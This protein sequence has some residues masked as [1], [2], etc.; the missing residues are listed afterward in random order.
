MVL[1]GG[2]MIHGLPKRPV[3]ILAPTTG[4][5]PSPTSASSSATRLQL[6]L[7]AT[8]TLPQS[9][10]PQTPQPPPNVTPPLDATATVLLSQIMLPERPLICYRQFGPVDGVRDHHLAVEL[11]RRSLVKEWEDKGIL[12]TW[13]TV[14]RM[15]RQSI[16]LWVF[17]VSSDD[18]AAHPSSS[19]DAL[20]FDDMHAIRSGRFTPRDLYPCS[21]TCNHPTK[22]CDNCD[23]E[24]PPIQNNVPSSCLLPRSSLRVPFATFLDAL[25]GRLID[26]I[27]QQQRHRENRR[28]TDPPILR[29]NDG[30]LLGQQAHRGSWEQ[31]WG[32]DAQA[33]TSK[34]V[35]CQ[36]H[37]S[38]LP[39]RLLVQ[40]I[41]TKAPLVPL[42]PTPPAGTPVVL[43]PY[44]TPAYYLGPYIG[45]K[46]E[47]RAS[48]QESLKGLGCRSWEEQGLI[49]CWLTVRTGSTPNAS[50]AA[51]GPKPPTIQERGSMV[52]W[53]IS[54]CFY[55]TSTS[56]QPLV[57]LPS[58]PSSVCQPI[59]PPRTL[60]TGANVNPTA[61]QAATEVVHSVSEEAASPRTSSVAD[62]LRHSRTSSLGGIKA[63]SADATMV[64]FGPG[65]DTVAT[66]MG[67]YVEWTVKEREREKE[68]LVKEKERERERAKKDVERP[69]G[70][71]VLP[72]VRS[73]EPRLMAQQ[74]S[75]GS[76]G[77][78]TDNV[79]PAGIQRRAHGSI[80]HPE[81]YYPSP[82]DFNSSTSAPIGVPSMLGD[83]I[84]ST[85]EQ[86][87]VTQQPAPV[88]DWNMDIAT[89][90]FDLT[91]ASM[92]AGT[93]GFDTDTV[94][95]MTRA[96]MGIEDEFT[97]DDFNFFDGPQVP[98]QPQL[99]GA[100]LVDM[101]PPSL[102]KQPQVD[103]TNPFDSTSFESAGGP[104]V[105]WMDEFLSGSQV[106]QES[107]SLNTSYPDST[108]NAHASSDPSYLTSEI[109]QQPQDS[110]IPSPAHIQQSHD[111][112][113][114]GSALP[115]SPLRTPEPSTIASSPYT[116]ASAE[117]E[118]EEEDLPPAPADT[119]HDLPPEFPFRLKEYVAVGYKAIPFGAALTTA[120]QKYTGPGGKFNPVGAD[121]PPYQSPSSDPPELPIDDS[122]Y[123]AN[124]FLETVAPIQQSSSTAL[125]SKRATEHLLLSRTPHQPEDEVEVY[126]KTL[127]ARL[128]KLSNKPARQ[129]SFEIWHSK[130]FFDK[131]ST[132]TD[133]RV[134]LVKRLRGQK[135]RLEYTPYAYLRS[136]GD[137]D[138]RDLGSKLVEFEDLV[139]A[140]SPMDDADEEE[141]SDNESLRYATDGETLF[142]GE[143]DATGSGDGSAGIRIIR[144]DD[145][146]SP[147][148]PEHMRE[149]R[150]PPPAPPIP[151]TLGASLL[152]TLCH[153]AHVV[154]L[155]YGTTFNTILAP[156][157]PSPAPVL[158]SVP[159]PVSPAAHT[160]PA[161]ES[162][163]LLEAAANVASRE[164]MEN[165]TW[166]L[167]Y[168]A[169][170][171]WTE[172]DV[173]QAS[174]V[175]SVAELLKLVPHVQHKTA[176][177]QLAYLPEP[178]TYST[179]KKPTIAQII[180]P[181]VIATSQAG[182]PI[183]LGATSLRFWNKLGLTPLNGTKDVAA[184][185]LYEEESTTPEHISILSQWMKDVSKVYSDR[186]LGTQTIGGNSTDYPSGLV[187][188]KWDSVKKTLGGLVRGLPAEVA[189]VVLYFITTPPMTTTSV[190]EFRQLS[191]AMTHAHSGIH[192]LDGRVLVH[193]VPK[194]AVYDI[195][196]SSQAWHLGLDKFVQCVYD[197]L[198]R[199]VER[200]V[201]RQIF[202]R[203]SLKTYRFLQS[204]SWTLARSTP[205][206]SFRLIDW[207][208]AS[209]DVVDR[210]AMLHVA[211]EVSHCSNFVT[212]CGVDA[213]GEA[214]DARVLYIGGDETDGSEMDEK[215]A[216]GVMTFVW[217]FCSRTN[218][219][220]NVIIARP[221]AMTETELIAWEKCLMRD[222]LSQD[223]AIHVTIACMEIDTPLSFLSASSETGKHSAATP[224]TP[225]IAH[226]AHHPKWMFTDMSLTNMILSPYYRTPLLGIN[227]P[228]FGPDILSVDE[229]ISLSD[230]ASFSRIGLLPLCSS[231]LFTSP[232]IADRTT[233]VTPGSQ[234]YGT[235]ISSLRFHIL[236]TCCSKSSS[237]RKRLHD[238]QDEILR[239]YCSL[240]VVSRERWSTSRYGGL[241]FHVAAVLIMKGALLY[242]KEI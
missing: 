62:R 222:V 203:Q 167:A 128:R 174:S 194:S 220:W 230:S 120:S 218:A 171:G 99:P 215:V 108:T 234:E 175:D 191:A 156:A 115:S 4:Q 208:P 54:L 78:E 231:Y 153:P 36:L 39:T 133:P 7:P 69:E 45:P 59:S 198:L 135:R 38:L 119:G 192:G 138:P 122:I 44:G 46:E 202:K 85:T 10:S 236:H 131:F 205:S 57:T 28:E 77:P 90:V 201:P 161:G 94:L 206:F 216:G 132:D 240:A 209:T 182:V 95:T 29:L 11:V 238:L 51:L 136:T 1:S 229:D 9:Q 187:P 96:A 26:K 70:L 162:A 14:V 142:V 137:R 123:A 34:L 147:A 213:N 139:S 91:D 55:P 148:V 145:G 23:Q 31:Y 221:S 74:G 15:E 48:F 105:S 41:L 61:S 52:V 71:S 211:Y 19:L 164:V 75:A 24:R 89:G 127:R 181:P 8:Q 88:Q 199:R 149:P 43:L 66:E 30:F 157:V 58:I 219:E 193:F 12:D 3:T 197:R 53:P 87:D 160:S 141:D 82:P 177:H 178:P 112:Q 104:G 140:P 165:P 183:Q 212:I 25:R 121:T 49:V 83:P 176:L 185:A 241:P 109:N 214:H 235:V 22:G 189:H 110:S 114:T 17:T 72:E 184:F 134:K 226:S 228:S 103:I 190:R 125:P 179:D 158:M 180:K 168:C 188:F 80:S 101:A 225:H 47:A 35:H 106:P 102:R 65:M 63:L 146:T 21:P 173:V 79:L 232:L 111:I 207:P 233:N 100:P 60:A 223:Q 68:R 37:L 98:Q 159:T 129:G 150:T 204:Y 50:T 27:S 144:D 76:L 124:E 169:Q 195:C 18:P 154:A 163:V 5:R 107:Q 143:Q 113:H 186:R 239:S 2:P 237:M 117:E 86:N 227:T 84:F 200:I 224:I 33:P 67:S 16:S 217:N 97:E 6:P 13:L 155:T 130:K 118:E 32:S 81:G 210:H 42:S 242:S 172:S 166:A 170:F 116:K 40:P 73:N 151:V 56:R 92:A 93:S 196:G 20:R 126:R 152:H 64:K